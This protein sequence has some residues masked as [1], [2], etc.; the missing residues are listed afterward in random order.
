MVGYPHGLT[1]GP[2]AS[3]VVVAC[4][5]ECVY[6][7]AVVAGAASQV[8]GV[9][10][11]AVVRDP[12]RGSVRPDPAAL[13][14]DLIQSKRLLER[15]NGHGRSAEHGR[16]VDVG[17]GDGHVDGVVDHI[18]GV[19]VGVLVVAHRQREPVGVFGLMVEGGLGAELTRRRIEV[20]R[21]G[22]GPG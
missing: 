9:H 6:V 21:G 3:G 4:G 14:V 1:V 20:E 19:A 12:H 8:V 10:G 5:V 18:V 17:D 16:L 2:Q 7:F 15:V 11:A 22:V 13:A